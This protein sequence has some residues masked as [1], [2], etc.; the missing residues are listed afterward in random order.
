MVQQSGISQGE[1][2]WLWTGVGVLLSLV[3]W[4]LARR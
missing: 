2:D 3:W 4:L 1:V